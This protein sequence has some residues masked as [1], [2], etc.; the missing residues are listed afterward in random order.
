VQTCCQGAYPQGIQ[1]FVTIIQTC[2]CGG[3]GGG[4]PCANQ[5]VAEY[6]LNGGVNTPG[7]ACDNCLGQY[8]AAGAT[9]DAT[10]PT[11]SINKQC[12]A[13]TQCDAYQVCYLGCK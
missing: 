7:D 8:T 2:L 6:C 1:N 5:C 11:S 9:C 13:D 10:T 3:T 12:Q 4:G